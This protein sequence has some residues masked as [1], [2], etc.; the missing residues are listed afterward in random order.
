MQSQIQGVKGKETV[1]IIYESSS[2]PLCVSSSLH[3]NMVLFIMC[4]LSYI[5]RKVLG[6][7]KVESYLLSPRYFHRCSRMKKGMSA[8]ITIIT[9]LLTNLIFQKRVNVVLVFVRSQF[10]WSFISSAS[11]KREEGALQYQLQYLDLVLGQKLVNS[12][13]YS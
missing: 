1:N 5:Q 6:R 8:I 3:T 13:T 2:P 12:C 7:G 9:V 10:L 11:I 4:F